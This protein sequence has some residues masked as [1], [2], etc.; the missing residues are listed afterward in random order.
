MALR[1]ISESQIVL[2]E[3]RNRVPGFV[4]AWAQCL[5]AGTAS[6]LSGM[7]LKQHLDYNTAQLTFIVPDL[8]I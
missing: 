5:R 4:P 8:V 7:W 2:K 3:N 1:E 6:P